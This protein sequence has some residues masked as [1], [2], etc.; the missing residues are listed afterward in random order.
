MRQ[1][2][3]SPSVGPRGGKPNSIVEASKRRIAASM[4]LGSLQVGIISDRNLAAP[5]SL[6]VW[7]WQMT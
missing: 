5:K 4:G 3:G 6:R 2:Q 1:G 7:R